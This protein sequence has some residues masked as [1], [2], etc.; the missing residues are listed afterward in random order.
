M[1]Q[2]ASLTYDTGRDLAQSTGFSKLSFRTGN[3]ADE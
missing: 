2:I 1:I 3:G